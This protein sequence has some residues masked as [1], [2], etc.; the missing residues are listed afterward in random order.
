MNK[1]HRLEKWRFLV[2]LFIYLV[3]SLFIFRFVSVLMPV[4]REQPRNTRTIR[5]LY[6]QGLSSTFDKLL[7]MKHLVVIQ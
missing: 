4:L 6:V 7:E 3:L 5:T 2:I 1:N